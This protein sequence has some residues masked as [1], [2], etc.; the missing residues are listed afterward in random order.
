MLVHGRYLRLGY[1]MAVAFVFVPS[2]H[3][4]ALGALLTFAPR[5]WYPLYAGRAATAGVDA[6]QDQQLAGLI[7]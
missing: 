5:V 6:L 7:M 1:G 3:S 2:V 4:E